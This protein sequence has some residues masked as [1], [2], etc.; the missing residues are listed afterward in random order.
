MKP[1]AGNGQIFPAARLAASGLNRLAIFDLAALPPDLRQQLAEIV[2]DI[3]AYRQLILLAH[4]GRHLWDCVTASARSGADP[5]DDFTTKRITEC[6]AT[7]LPG[8]PYRFLYPG[9]E[10]IGLQQLGSLAGW[11]DATPFMLGIDKEWGSWWAYRAVLLTDSAFAP[12][13]PSRQIHPCTACIDQPCI[14]A[15]P[16]KALAGG[17]LSLTHCLDFRRQDNSPC[18]FTCLAR[19]A[20]PVGAG[21]RYSAAQMRHVYGISLKWIKGG[22]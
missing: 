7:D 12:S 20:C 9:T 4:G 10:Q 16:A 5:I 6:F 15:C 8:L 11:H 13:I 14:S 1:P 17:Q 22:L 19:L 18:Q 2:P 3:D 21:H